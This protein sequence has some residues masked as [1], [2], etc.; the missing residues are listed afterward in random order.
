MDLGGHALQL[1]VLVFLARLLDPTAF[2]LVG[3]ALVTIATLEQFTR[4]GFNEAIIQHEDENVDRYLDTLW[5]VQLVRGGAVA[6][7]LFSGAPLVAAFF[8]EPGVVDLLRVMAALPVLRALT[9]PGIVYF[10]KNLTFHKQ[11]VYQMTASVAQFLVA[12]GIALVEPSVWALVFGYLTAGV[13]QV[14]GSYALQSFRPRPRFDTEA[15]RELFD[16]GKW[17][18]G[19]SIIS[20]LLTNL[21]ELVIGRLMPT[22]ALG[23]YQYGFRLGRYTSREFSSIIAEVMFPTFSRLQDDLSALR[24]AFFHTLSFNVVLVFPMAVG[25]IVVVPLFVRGFLGEEWIPVVPVFQLVSLYGML[26]A[27]IGRGD[28]LLKAIGRPDY[29][30]KVRLVWLVAFVLLIVPLTERFGITGAAL[31]LVGSYALTEVPLT[32]YLVLNYLQTSY[33][34]FFRTLSYPLAASLVMG[35]VTFFARERVDVGSPFLE[36]FLVVP[37]GVVTYSALVLGF[38]QWSDWEIDETYTLIRKAIQS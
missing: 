13:F 21:D 27:A 9:N 36:F 19:S 5:S 30:T 20:F 2:G 22:A 10:A 16:F 17:V 4:P 12:I 7:V 15:A 29:R 11:F 38:L 32:L 25:G 8:N 23:L 26:S 34:R 14:V 24:E 31:A 18:T 35:S 6:L 33:S 37:I 1:V 3:I 28:I